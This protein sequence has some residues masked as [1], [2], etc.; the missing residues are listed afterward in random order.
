MKMLCQPPPHRCYKIHIFRAQAKIGEV[1]WDFPRKV[2]LDPPPSEMNISNLGV[3][4]CRD[5]LVGLDTKYL[6][7]LA[8]ASSALA[9]L[10]YLT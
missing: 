3:L 4:W 7:P 8:L 9:G 10:T 5:L 6:G 1:I 2:F